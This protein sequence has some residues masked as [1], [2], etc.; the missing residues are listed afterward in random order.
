M[1]ASFGASDLVVFRCDF[2][3]AIDEVFLKT[4]G[5]A[6]IVA[7]TSTRVAA[8]IAAGERRRKPHG[9]VERK[10]AN[11]CDWVPSCTVSLL[12]LA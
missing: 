3:L 1:A 7:A 6:T 2:F 4:V 9:R 12:A 5:M 8:S 11:G 10:S